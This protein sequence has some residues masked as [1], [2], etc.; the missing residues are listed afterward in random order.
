MPG[1]R[2][3]A[4]CHRKQTARYR[5]QPS[6]DCGRYQ[7][8]RAHVVKTRG[9]QKRPET[10]KNDDTKQHLVNSIVETGDMSRVGLLSMMCNHCMRPLQAH[11]MSVQLFPMSERSHL[12]PACLH[13]TS[14]QMPFVSERVALVSARLLRHLFTAAFCLSRSLWFPSRLQSDVSSPISTGV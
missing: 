13:S 11:R 2:S 12:K 9:G 8:R 5:Q 3:Q 4:L 14:E 7:K 10:A 1:C 6:L